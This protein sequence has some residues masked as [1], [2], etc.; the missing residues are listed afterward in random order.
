ML[1]FAPSIPYMAASLFKPA[2]LRLTWPTRS[3]LAWAIRSFRGLGGV[4]FVLVSEILRPSL[5]ELGGG[6][7]GGLVEDV[8]VLVFELITIEL[9]CLHTCC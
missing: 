3:R 2:C 9:Y 7:V 1:A 5:F 8:L 4:R 6:W